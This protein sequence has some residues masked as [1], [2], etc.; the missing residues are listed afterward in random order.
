MADRDE[1]REMISCKEA[2][3]FLY[4]FLDGELEDAPSEQ[5]R[6]HFD[7]CQRCYPHLKLEAAFRAVLQRACGGPCAPPELESRLL[8]ALDEAEKG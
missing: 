4:E 8:A 7:V 3:R 5:V 6:A 2:L 1:G